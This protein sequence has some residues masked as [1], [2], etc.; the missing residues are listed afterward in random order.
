MLNAAGI[1]AHEREAL[2]NKDPERKNKHHGKYPTGG[3]DGKR[4]SALFTRPYLSVYC[5]TSTPRAASGSLSDRHRRTTV[6]PS[7]SPAGAKSRFF[8]NPLPAR[9]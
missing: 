3:S 5:I 1:M 2:C 8:V 4:A 9:D 7:P 6:D